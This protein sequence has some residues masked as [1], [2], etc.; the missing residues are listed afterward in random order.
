MSGGVWVIVCG[1]S[2]AGKDSVIGWAANTLAHEPAIVF[3][4]RSVTRANAFAGSDDELDAGAMAQRRAA[5]KLAWHWEA[6]GLH[7]GV[8]SS[9]TAQVAAGRVV[10]VNGSRAHAASLGLRADVR[11]V[12]VSAPKSVLAQRLH[13]RGRE[14]AAQVAGRLAR[15]ANIPVF[16]PDL[17]IANDSDLAQAGLRL[18][19]YLKEL[20]P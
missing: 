4:R 16:T 1:P 14:G 18:A 3:A 11:Y 6:H 9:Y 12:L 20:S 2:G 19:A 10:V 15:S 13:S 17:E 8:D 5:G 7:Y